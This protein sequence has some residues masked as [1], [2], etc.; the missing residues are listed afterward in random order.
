MPLTTDVVTIKVAMSITATE[1]FRDEQKDDLTLAIA[2]E[3]GVANTA[4]ENLEVASAASQDRRRRELLEGDSAY[5]AWS[6]EFDIVTQH[7]TTDEFSAEIVQFLSTTSFESTVETYLGIV[8][9]SVEEVLAKVIATTDDDSD[10]SNNNGMGDE[11]LEEALVIALTVGASVVALVL[12]VGLV[13]LTLGIRRAERRP[14][15]FTER[16][17]AAY[18]MSTV[19]APQSNECTAEGAKEP[20]QVMPHQPA[21]TPAR[22]RLHAIDF[23]AVVTDEGEG[24]QKKDQANTNTS[25]HDVVTIE[26][27]GTGVVATAYRG[28]QGNINV[29]L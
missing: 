3:L 8:G 25:M 29:L 14:P 18:R 15:S 1:P 19:I 28:T 17:K 11:K 6:I 2:S 12:V 21:A 9:V 5:Y 16:T 27:K 7:S 10:D 13:V 4:I 26:C 24:R 22:A 20:R 23:E